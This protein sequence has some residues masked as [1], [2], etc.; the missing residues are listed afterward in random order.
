MEETRIGAK[1]GACCHY[2]ATFGNL[3]VEALAYAERD[4]D[5]FMA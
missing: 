5:R 3:Q 4:S 1:E 2:H